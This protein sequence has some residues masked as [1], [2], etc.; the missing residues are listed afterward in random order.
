MSFRMG[1]NLNDN[2][3]EASKHTYGSTYWNSNVNHK[4]KRTTDSQKRRKYV[5]KR[6]ALP[7]GLRGTG[8]WAV[9]QRHVQQKDRRVKN[10]R[11]L[12]HVKLVS[13]ETSSSPDDSCDSFASDNFVNNKT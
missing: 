7:A 12:R 10:F 2:R 5:L 11:K 13:M 8:S 9:G 6:R 4:S 3:F 1:L